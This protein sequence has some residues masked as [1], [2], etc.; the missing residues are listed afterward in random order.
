MVARSSGG[1]KW[2]IINTLTTAE[3]VHNIGGHPFPKHDASGRALYLVLAPVLALAL[4]RTISSRGLS[5]HDAPATDQVAR[6]G[7]PSICA[8]IIAETASHARPILPD[9]VPSSHLLYGCFDV[10]VE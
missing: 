10:S 1:V 3:S 2:D 7:E 8:A 4:L 9:A 5:V 6:L